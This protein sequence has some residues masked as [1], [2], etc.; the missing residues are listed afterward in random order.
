[1]FDGN[2]FSSIVF[3]RIK[4]DT[5]PEVH[6]TRPNNGQKSAAVEKQFQLVFINVNFRRKLIFIKTHTVYECVA[7]ETP[8]IMAHG[9]YLK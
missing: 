2:R 7:F 5:Y 1:M 8:G 9:H 3:N 6:T 4:W